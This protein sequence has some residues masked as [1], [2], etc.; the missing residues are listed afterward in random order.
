MSAQPIKVYAEFRTELA[1]LGKLNKSLKFDYED[2]TENKEARSHVHKLR[3]TRAALDRA[4]KAEKASSLEYGRR[5]DSEA[6]EIADQITAMIDAHQGPIDEI[7]RREEA[8]MAKHAE[9]LEQLRALGTPTNEPRSAAQLCEHIDEVDELAALEWEEYAELA[10]KAAADAREYLRGVLESERERVARDAELA[11]LRKDAADREAKDAADRE[12]RERKEREAR[13]AVEAEK[14]AAA[15]A[16]EREKRE[17]KI[18]VDTESRV[19]REAAEAQAK[20]ERKAADELAKQERIEQRRRENEKHVTKVKAEAAGAL[21]LAADVD[22]VSADKII[23]LI[24]AGA[25]P[26]VEI[27]F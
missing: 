13:E 11:Q 16:E 4:R 12:A 5:V 19:K 3:K 10:E 21:V 18:R 6:H 27:K 25:I 14:R 17:E 20:R 9:R 7:E 2:P 15:E 8:R 24:E 22:S 26:H 23:G 1:E